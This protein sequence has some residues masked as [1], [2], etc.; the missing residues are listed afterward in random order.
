MVATIQSSRRG[1][2]IGMRLLWNMM[3]FST[4]ESLKPDGA[5]EKPD[6]ESK[7]SR[8]F[9]KIASLATALGFGGAAASTASLRSSPVGFSFQ[10]SA[11]TFVAFAV[12]AAIALIYWKLVASN[13]K[14]ARRASLLIALAGVGLFLYPLRFVPA[15]NLHDLAVGLILATCALSIVGFLLWRVKRFLDTDSQQADAGAEQP[16]SPLKSDRSSDR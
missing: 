15:G 16:A 6:S 13:S 1:A 5:A 7:S 8:V 11:A 10:L 4:V 9:F 2:E 3:I 14:A 12:G